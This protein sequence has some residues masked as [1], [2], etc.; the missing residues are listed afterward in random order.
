MSRPHLEI[1]V[2][3]ALL[4]LFGLVASF[5]GA[6]L[7]ATVRE[8]STGMQLSAAL[9]APFAL[10]ATVLPVLAA[11]MAQR[12]LGAWM[13]AAELTRPWPPVARFTA[14]LALAE[15]ATLAVRAA[16]GD[17]TAPLFV[18]GL[19]AAHAAIAAALLGQ[20]FRHDVETSRSGA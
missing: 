14:L 13:P 5:A 19:L 4:A 3:G 1:L 17:G 8:P 6:F 10:L 15:A 11:P 16:V 20:S 18:H 2:T 7:W 9:Y 12:A